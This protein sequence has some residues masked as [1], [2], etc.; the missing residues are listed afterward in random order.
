MKDMENSRRAPEKP[1]TVKV[2]KTG[3]V[4]SVGQFGYSEV[5]LSGLVYVSRVSFVSD[6]LNGIFFSL[7]FYRQNRL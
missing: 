1:E 4:S 5:S 6:V 2:R 7:G 3:A